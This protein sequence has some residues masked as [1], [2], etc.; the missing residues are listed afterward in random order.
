MPTP[1]HHAHRDPAVASPSDDGESYT[2]FDADSEGEPEVK[3]VAEAAAAVELKPKKVPPNLG[4]GTVEEVVDGDE[5]SAAA[6]KPSA[7]MFAGFGSGIWSLGSRTASLVG[8]VGSLVKNAATVVAGSVEQLSHNNSVATGASL[9]RESLEALTEILA[10]KLAQWLVS[11]ANSEILLGVMQ[12]AKKGYHRVRSHRGRSTEL[13][14]AI[15]EVAA[16]ITRAPVVLMRLLSCDHWTKAYSINSA[17]LNWELMGELLAVFRSYLDG[18]LM[19]GEPDERGLTY[20]LCEALHEARFQPGREFKLLF[21]RLALSY[22][23]SMLG[24]SQSASATAVSSVVSVQQPDFNLVAERTLLARELYAWML[25]PASERVL[26]TALAVTSGEYH[27]GKT[28]TQGRSSEI[29]QLLHECNRAREALSPLLAITRL[30]S[31]QSSW[32]E[33]GDL[34]ATSLNNRLMR[35]VVNSFTQDLMMQMRGGQLPEDRR[36]LAA[37][38][39]LNVAVSQ[40]VPVLPEANAI[41]L[42]SRLS[43]VTAANLEAKRAEVAAAWQQP[44]PVATASATWFGSRR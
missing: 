8:G 24:Q 10:V 21:D 25:N 34:R 5:A 36:S 30:W 39:V 1:K 6:G 16:D 27:A 41:F 17:P 11:R 33:G 43:E 13:E 2:D 19:A 42:S 26:L 3:T 20:S 40:R 22:E 29:S 31:A 15:T 35:H 23:Q 9:E 7:S 12:A 18:R 44:E 28:T 4:G 37:R 14:A 38:I 32:N